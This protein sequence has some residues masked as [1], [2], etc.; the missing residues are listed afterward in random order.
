M[1]TT[2]RDNTTNTSSGDVRRKLY[3]SD[4]PMFA[5]RN[6]GTPR[7]SI[8]EYRR[9]RK[10]NLAAAA[11]ATASDA[12]IANKEQERI[13]TRPIS[14]LRANGG[15]GMGL[16]EAFARTDDNGE[17]MPR[18]RAAFGG[19]EQTVS[20]SRIPR[21]STYS[22]KAAKESPSPS[23]ADR[24]AY[25]LNGKEGRAF[26]APT[27]EYESEDTGAVRDTSP[28]PGPRDRRW[29]SE[30]NRPDSGSDASNHSSM[31][32]FRHEGLA[33]FE[34]RRR[35]LEKDMVKD[36]AYYE[37]KRLKTERDLRLQ[38]SAL[39]STTPLFVGRHNGDYSRVLGTA[40]TLERK[41][42]ES[43]LDEREPPIT[44]PSTWGS[45]ARK[46][47]E[48]MQKILSPDTSL[49]LNDP[50][51]APNAAER[52]RTASDIIVPSVED[53]SLTQEITPP[54][55]R[56]A[57]AQ[58]IN[59][60]PEKSRPW[61]ADL[62]FTAQSLQI[63]TSPQLRV[64]STSRLD[65]LRSRE[66]LNLTA[67]AVATNRLEEIRER[68]SEERS[69]IA[70]PEQAKAEYETM[71]AKEAPKKTFKDEAK[72]E[73]AMEE[74]HERTILEEEGEQIPFTPITVFS[75][76]KDFDDYAKRNNM[77]LISH[78]R[79]DSHELLKRLSR[80]LSSSRSPSP[81]ESDT[82]K[83]LDPVEDR[84]Q[85]PNISGLVKESDPTEDRKARQSF[86]GQVN[87]PDPKQAGK[88]DPNFSDP[89]KNS[90]PDDPEERIAAEARLFDLQD[91]SEKGSIRAPSPLDDETPRPKPDPLS[92]PTPKV[93]GAY[94]ETPFMA[95]KTRSRSPRSR[96]REYRPSSR[97]KDSRPSL[98]NTATHVSAIEDLRRIQLESNV[99]DSTLD[100]LEFIEDAPAA[101]GTTTIEPVLDLEYNDHG[102]P[103]SQREVERRIEEIT[104][105]RMNKSLKATSTSIRDARK[106][107]ERL[108]EQVSS[109]FVT[110][111][112]TSQSDVMYINVKIPVPKLWIAQP[113]LKAGMKAGWKFT[114]LGLILSIFGFWF[115][116]ES[117]MCAQ[118]C[119]PTNSR[120]NTWQPSD[121]F[122]P[123]A[124]PTK[125]DQWTGEIVSTG[126]STVAEAFGMNGGWNLGLFP[127]LPSG[128]KGGPIGAKDWWLG[129][130]GPIGL[131]ADRD[132]DTAITDDEMI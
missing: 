57:S 91:K 83:H 7:E 45:R 71:A 54:A 131:K 70:E 17:L 18:T 22:P 75:K 120:V 4:K 32:G 90:E 100:D 27:I 80:S 65:E 31:D 107:I 60:S 50:V 122:F 66:I 126:V 52:Q 98:V 5:N 11:N 23:R 24:P 106:G 3:H 68:N 124:I 92:L 111:T 105:E 34:R 108:E 118:F 123:W 104:L 82:G 103:L 97:F 8:W 77:N 9:N 132:S 55:S 64:K 81:K 14:W 53:R 20:D 21:T 86:S 30:E 95:T 113:P 88:E 35:E 87:D 74:Y 101:E 41:A 73:S 2:D 99:E 109:S 39:E 72:E 119:H 36:D 127:D 16:A 78:N 93:S 56:P 59:A 33:Y 48:W 19:T 94:I 89:V 58:P 62:D 115:L 96:T 114:W 121:P 47:R 51:E 67:R 110:V 26:S 40:R 63:S 6:N 84:R 10:A 29:S 15:R 61:D 1:A 79:S 25:T 43:S 76:A 12:P 129:R 42:S 13:P 28:S 46:N 49:E 44:V 128:Y 37:R 85:S 112:P 102:L 125:L 38:K 130:D 69:L 117:A 116:S